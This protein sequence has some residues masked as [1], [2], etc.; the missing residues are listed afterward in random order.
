MSLN[1]LKL[2]EI[3]VVIFVDS[4]EQLFDTLPKFNIAPEK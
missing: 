3:N 4:D 1:D 2:V